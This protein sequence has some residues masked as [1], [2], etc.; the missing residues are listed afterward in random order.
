MLSGKTVKNK[1][2][3]LRREQK[4]LILVAGIFMLYIIACNY[5]PI[6]GWALSLF[7]YKPAFGLRFSKQKFVLFDNFIKLWK[8]RRELFH[9]LRNTLA[10]SGLSLLC[11]PLPMLLAILFSELRSRSFMRVAQT[12]TTFPNF[13]S[14][15][16]IY[17]V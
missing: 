9:V 5:V 6:A 12:V 10:L 15:I 14:W 16:I 13:I 2:K 4:V 1:K 8:E 7:R 17:G 3:P 11:A